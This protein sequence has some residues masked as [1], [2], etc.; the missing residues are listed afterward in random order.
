MF[1]QYSYNPCTPKYW[2]FSEC[3][4]FL[5]NPIDDFTIDR[6]QMR[7]DNEYNTE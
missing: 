2:S 1:A 5:E 7:K 6:G 4:G 3:E